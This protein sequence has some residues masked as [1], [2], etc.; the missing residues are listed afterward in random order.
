M[1]IKDRMREKVPVTFQLWKTMQRFFEDQVNSICVRSQFERPSAGASQTYIHAA[2][3]P[4]I[5]VA[6]PH[7]S[8]IHSDSCECRR[9]TQDSD[10]GQGRLSRRWLI[11][12]CN[13]RDVSPVRR[14]ARAA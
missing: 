10:S 13:I 7:V 4:H 11:F 5:H 14:S 8:V 12:P 6:V 9:E 3:I 2:L 1:A